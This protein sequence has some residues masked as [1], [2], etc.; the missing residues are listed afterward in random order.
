LSPQGATAS[1]VIDFAGKLEETSS[2]FYEK[3]A[4][5]F[6][7]NKE[8][9]LSFA[10]ESK[11]NKVLIIRTYQETITDA[12]EA[13]FCFKDLNLGDYKIPAALEKNPSYSDALKLAIKDE[14]IAVQFYS[15]IA[16]LARG[17]LAT[18][19]MVFVKVA[20]RR[21]NREFALKSLLDG[22]RI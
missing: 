13:C 19:P 4:E 17:L 3:L 2:S 6:A 1:T 12:L 18:I 15:K 21:R 10:E 8:Q 7:E 9:F 22:G 14:Q 20:E 5:K 11:K 16:E